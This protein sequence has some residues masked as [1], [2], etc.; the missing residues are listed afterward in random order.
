MRLARSEDAPV[1]LAALTTP[2]RDN[3]GPPV[4]PVPGE[5]LRRLSP[6]R[7]VV[8]RKMTEAWLTIPAVT[9]HRP[10]PLA[11][12][13]AARDRLAAGGRKPALDILMAILVARALA[14]YDLL[15]GSWREDARAVV[16]HPTRN[17]AIAV[18]TPLGLTAVVLREADQRTPAELGG[19][20]V[21]MVARARDGRSL[22]GDV[23]DATFTITNLGGLGIESFTP[24]ITPPQSA[25][26]GIGAIRPEPA[27]E[28]P[29]A[30]SLTFD[31][32]VVDGADAARFLG[33]LAD[34][35][36]EAAF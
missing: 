9:L 14:E 16:V 31:H 4:S 35:A 32:R 28:R 26:L 36:R 33:R 12:V 23:A 34:L 2:S 18:D 19:A 6:I 7:R 24:I 3:P 22:P 1:A 29:A 11:S 30:V 5:D 17:I 15:N 25:V 10:L 27:A 20:L 8:A 21:D 13:L